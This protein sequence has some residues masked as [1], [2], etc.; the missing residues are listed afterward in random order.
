MRAIHAADLKSGSELNTDGKFI[1][2]LSAEN[3]QKLKNLVNQYITLINKQ[4][5][6]SLSTS[7]SL[8][9]WEK[10]IP[11]LPRGSPLR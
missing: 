9:Y 1:F 11:E 8:E 2:A 7:K 6:I 4:P 5:E 10:R 3:D